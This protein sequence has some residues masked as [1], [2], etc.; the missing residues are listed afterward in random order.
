MPVP[1]KPLTKEI[2]IA[3]SVLASKASRD[4][5]EW[6]KALGNTLHKC[7]SKEVEEFYG[8]LGDESTVS[9]ADVIIEAVHLSALGGADRGGMHFPRHWSLERRDDTQ[10]MSDDLTRKRLEKLVERI[11]EERFD[12]LPD[13]DEDECN[14]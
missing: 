6:F 14:E 12:E 5:Y 10:G 1:K 4:Q 8:G 13:E 2:S 9:I 3:T 7:V 11:D